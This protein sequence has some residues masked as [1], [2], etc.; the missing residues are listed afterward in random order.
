[1]YCSYYIE[2]IY[3]CIYGYQIGGVQ[4][5][6]G[7]KQKRNGNLDMSNF[8]SV[9]AGLR[10]EVLVSEQI[11]FRHAD[12]LFPLN[13]ESRHRSW[14]FFFFFFFGYRRTQV[15]TREPTLSTQS[16]QLALATF[17]QTRNPRKVILRYLQF[18]FRPDHLGFDLC[19]LC[20]CC[21]FFW[22]N[23]TR[24]WSCPEMHTYTYTL[25]VSASE[26][27]EI[28]RFAA[29]QTMLLFRL[30]VF[31]SSKIWFCILF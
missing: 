9:T 8:L 4:T 24:V 5:F 19:F 28:G 26:R 2:C 31:F 11:L 23:R 21:F 6:F 14:T 16:K 1:M 7:R 25:C 15:Q 18:R 3:I 10:S 27:G 17:L 29:Y 12:A 13:L 20:F 30:K 22:K